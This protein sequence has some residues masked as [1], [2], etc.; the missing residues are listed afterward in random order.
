MVSSLTTQHDMLSFYFILIFYILIKF[1]C[2]RNISLWSTCYCE[3]CHG[4]KLQRKSLNLLQMVKKR[5]HFVTWIL[6]IIIV[7]VV[8]NNLFLCLLRLC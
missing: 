8:N 3:S 2:A 6:R 7:V 1:S 4:S 5:K